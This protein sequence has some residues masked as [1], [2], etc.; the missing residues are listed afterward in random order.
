[1][2]QGELL[3]SFQTNYNEGVWARQGKI[4]SSPDKA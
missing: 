1:M 3:V 2:I 4:Q